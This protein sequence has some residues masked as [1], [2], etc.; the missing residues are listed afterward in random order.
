MLLF[1]HNLQ[2]RCYSCPCQGIYSNAVLFMRIQCHSCQTDA[3]TVHATA[4]GTVALCDVMLFMR[5]ESIQFLKVGFETDSLGHRLIYGCR[6]EGSSRA[7]IT[8]K[9]EYLAFVC[10]NLGYADS[11]KLLHSLTIRY[12]MEDE[13]GMP[14]KM[15]FYVHGTEV[16][17]QRLSSITLQR[18]RWLRTLLNK[19]INNLLGHKQIFLI[20]YSTQ[21]HGPRR[22]HNM[23]HHQPNKQLAQFRLP[24]HCQWT[25]CRPHLR[26]QTNLQLSLI[27]GLEKI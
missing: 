17:H 10:A 1:P 19:I 20:T 3:I 15:L 7:E 25:S 13:M 24:I 8:S 18:L 23:T 27:V 22:L 16:F 2:T 9:R 6:Q 21:T 12:L 5:H 14:S 26:Y 11:T 4:T